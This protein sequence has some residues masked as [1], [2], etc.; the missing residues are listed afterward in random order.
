MKVLVI[1]DSK[2][3]L[4][5]VRDILTVHNF[6][7][8]TADNGAMGLDAYAK[9]KPDIVTLDLAMPVMDGYETLKRM[10]AMDREANVIIL[11]ASEQQ[12]IL[13][14]CME[15]GAIGF[16]IKPFTAKELLAAIDRAWKAGSAKNVATMFSLAQNKIETGIRKLA[17]VFMPNLS[18]TSLSIMLSDLQVIRRQQSTQVLSSTLD[19]TQIK[20][21]P[22]VVEDLH[23][24]VPKASVG[25]IT[26][27]G[28][29]QRGAVISFMNV[30]DL[31]ELFEGNNADT[32][33][34]IAEFFNVFNSKIISE[35]SNSTHL[36]L[37]QEPIQVYDHSRY[38]DSELATEVT[39]A[40][41]DIIT[42]S[43]KIPVEVQLWF[44]SDK[45]FRV[46]F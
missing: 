19:V 14:R 34:K 30:Q 40:I 25:Y 18:A 2:A 1:D 45:I 12:E 23:V 44:N 31:R 39:N 13:E 20:V 35:L 43:K 36:V 16:V 28:G 5:L 10:L 9:F 22:N 26:E 38:K 11:T 33:G 37:T 24:Q 27:F 15:K 3:I 6:E 17:E 7:V 42:E 46:R 32:S 41:F 4:N 29:Q 21:V 8:M